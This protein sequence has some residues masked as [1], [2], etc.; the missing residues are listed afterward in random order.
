MTFQHWHIKQ[1]YLTVAI[2]MMIVAIDMFCYSNYKFVCVVIKGTSIATTRFSVVTDELSLATTTNMT[3]AIDDSTYSNHLRNVAIEDL[4][5]ATNLSDVAIACS[6]YSNHLGNVTIEDLPVV[7][8]LSNVSIACSTYS[9][10]LGNV[11]IV[12]STIAILSPRGNNADCNT[13]LALLL[14]CFATRPA[15]SNRYR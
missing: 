13:Y 14:H 3:V 8:N 15:C 6:T 11:A 4:S 12:S 9:N 5:V 10:H 2:G 7:T 1:L